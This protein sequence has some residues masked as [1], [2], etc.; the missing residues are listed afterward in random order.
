[1]KQIARA[2]LGLLLTTQA[3]ADVPTAKSH[4]PRWAQAI[5]EARGDWKDGRIWAVAIRGV[6]KGA[7]PDTLVVLPSPYESRAFQA[8]LPAL[9]PGLYG[10]NP[11]GWDCGGLQ[12]SELD[13]QNAAELRALVGDRPLT[14]G[15][16]ASLTRP[17]CPNVADDSAHP[18]DHYDR[19]LSRAHGS[20]NAQGIAVLALRG[21]AP[22][23]ARHDSADNQGGYNDTYVILNRRQQRAIELAGSTHAG[24]PG[25]PTANPNGTAQIRPGNYRV[26]PIGDYNQMPAWSV[27]RSDGCEGIPC[28]RDRNED[29]SIGADEHGSARATQILF[30]NGVDAKVC[31]SVGCLTLAP[32]TYRRFVQLLNHQPF[33]FTLVDANQPLR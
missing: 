21:V 28:W 20:Y 8:H 29:G 32:Q 16:S 23:G 26:L 25:D 10:S 17:D 2:V 1:M 19:L 5:M 24:W 6:R 14:L 33:N 13:I 3:Q 12:L 18:F 7:Y 22:D 30:H 27:R 31:Y 4:P 11:T 15:T 9:R